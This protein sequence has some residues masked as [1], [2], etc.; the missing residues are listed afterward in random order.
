MTITLCNIALWNVL[1][2]IFASLFVDDAEQHGTGL[3]LI[4]PVRRLMERP[5]AINEMCLPA[6]CGRAVGPFAGVRHCY[7]TTGVNSQAVSESG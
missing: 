4:K 3:A 5:R 1:A 7:H 2:I 6:V